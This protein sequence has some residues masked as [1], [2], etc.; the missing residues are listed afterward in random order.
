MDCWQRTR[1][2]GFTKDIRTFKPDGLVRKEYND[3]KI[4]KWHDP[5]TGKAVY[6]WNADPTYGDQYHVTPDGKNR[7]PHPDTGDTHIKPGE[8]VPEINK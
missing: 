5:K 8:R 2:T 7:M 4:I 3:G 1:S 6:E